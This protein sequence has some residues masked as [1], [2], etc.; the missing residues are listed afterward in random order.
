MKS[1]MLSDIQSGSLGPQHLANEA[2]FGIKG[3]SGSSHG[4]GGRMSLPHD[5]RL[6]YLQ[7]K[8]AP[9]DFPSLSLTGFV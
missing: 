3:E 1:R 8:G 9:V 6:Q 7:E 4:R 5:H 2:F